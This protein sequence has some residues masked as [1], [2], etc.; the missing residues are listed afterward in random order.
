[1]NHDKVQT[2]PE[3]DPKPIAVEDGFVRLAGPLS[4]DSI[5]DGEGLRAVL[6]AQGCRRKCPGCQN[7]ETWDETAG[8]AVSLD[9]IKERL[10]AMRG[11][12]GITFSGGEPMLQA[13]ALTEIAR[14]AKKEMG[15]NI[16]CFTGYTYE[17][18]RKLD[19]EKMAL[20]R[21]CD[22]LIDGPFILPQKDLTCRFRGSRNQRLLRLKNGEIE[23]IE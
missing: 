8:V 21:E 9:E 18:L 12:A 4:S 22:V 3:P 11:Q 14:W 15:W 2:W 16:W 20:V 5:V 7:P 13:R 17:T 23:E 6:F 1:M 10:S 19:D